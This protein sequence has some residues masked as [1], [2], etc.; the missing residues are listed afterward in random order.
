M[1]GERPIYPVTSISGGTRTMA[2]RGRPSG[3]GSTRRRSSEAFMEFENFTSVKAK[4]RRDHRV[5][6]GS[7]SLE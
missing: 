2:G 3:S 7:T 6:I 5:Q 1:V 4:T